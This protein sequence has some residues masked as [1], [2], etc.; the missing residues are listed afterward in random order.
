MKAVSEES[1]KHWRKEIVIN[2][3]NAD[4]LFYKE[5]RLPEEA[6]NIGG[7]TD[8]RVIS[9]DPYRSEGVRVFS[10]RDRG[11]AVAQ[12]IIDKY[13]RNVEIKV[14]DTPEQCF[15]VRSFKESFNETF[16]SEKL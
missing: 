9:L 12:A 13:G 16:K 5:N 15:V 1:T 14:P 8:N 3:T 11:K 4:L 6:Y 7:I 10:G 2:F